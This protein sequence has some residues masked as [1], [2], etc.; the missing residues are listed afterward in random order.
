LN[1]RYGIIQ[2]AHGG[3]MSVFRKALFIWTM[4]AVLPGVAFSAPSSGAR[5]VPRRNGPIMDA[6]VRDSKIVAEAEVVSVSA[7]RNTAQGGNIALDVDIFFKVTRV[8]K[9]Q[10]FVQAGQQVVV[11]RPTS[12]N[13]GN[14]PAA[15]IMQQAIGGNGAQRPG[16]AMQQVGERYILFLIDE[17]TQGGAMA[18]RRAAAAP[19]LPGISRYEMLKVEQNGTTALRITSGKVQVDTPTL[20]ADLQGKDAQVALAEIARLT[21]GPAPAAGAQAPAP[22]AAVQVAPR[23]RGNAGSAAAPL[24][25][26]SGTVVMEGTAPR[27]S[28]QLRLAGMGISQSVLVSEASF[29]VSVPDGQPQQISITDLPAGYVVRSVTDGGSGN[30]LWTTLVARAGAPPPR[31]VV[32]IGGQSAGR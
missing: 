7:P 11:A 10:A 4:F 19:A 6:M 15:A 25:A 9:G 27:P 32:T 21:G 31:I 23:G 16:I 24:V 3:N 14:G 20:N 30:L 12:P 5:G 1:Y 18:A 13:G 29:S 22:V 2:V 17:T 26:V 28:F 8:H